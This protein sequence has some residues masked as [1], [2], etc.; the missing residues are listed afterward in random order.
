MLSV[1]DLRNLTRGGWRAPQP[2]QKWRASKWVYAQADLWSTTDLNRQDLLD[3]FPELRECVGGILTPGLRDIPVVFIDHQDR[4]LGGHEGDEMT[5]VVTLSS[6]WRVDRKG[7]TKPVPSGRKKKPKPTETPIRFKDYTINK[8]KLHDCPQPLLNIATEPPP[9]RP[10]PSGMQPIMGPI[11]IDDAFVSE[12]N[13]HPPPPRKTEALIDAQKAVGTEIPADGASTGDAKVH[14]SPPPQI[15]ALLDADQDKRLVMLLMS[16]E[17]PLGTPCDPRYKYYWLGLF[18]VAWIRDK[19]NKEP[20]NPSREHS[21]GDVIRWKFVF[22]YHSGSYPEQ[23]TG[24]WKN[25]RGAAPVLLSKE[26][27]DQ[28]KRTV[29]PRDILITGKRPKSPVSDGSLSEAGTSKGLAKPNG[30]SVREELTIFGTTDV[31]NAWYLEVNNFD[32]LE[33]AQDPFDVERFGTALAA[34]RPRPGSDEPSPESVWIQDGA[35][36]WDDG[37]VTTPYRSV[38]D[39]SEYAVKHVALMRNKALIARASERYTAIQVVLPLE[40]RRNLGKGIKADPLFELSDRVPPSDLQYP[41]VTQLSQDITKYVDIYVEEP[42]QCIKYLH[43]MAWTQ[44]GSQIPLDLANEKLAIL[45]YGCS[46]TLSITPDESLAKELESSGKTCLPFEFKMAHG[47]LAYVKKRKLQLK[48]KR[49]GPSIIVV[50][51]LS[52]ADV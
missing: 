38:L 39:E 52:K 14:R 25:A 30:A 20:H 45:T 17:S 7:K 6:L 3:C 24:W 33:Y 19:D 42:E 48:V 26:K 43:I 40:R 23:P 37:V 32:H 15:Q 28:Y 49:T 11:R 2:N 1:V 18:R 27:I 51:S 21:Y 13:A 4:F 8:P 50:G 35:D 47:D 44:E 46:I 22:S 31:Q 12:A 41:L 10:Q 34:P 16:H 36:Q 9:S 5:N 29:L